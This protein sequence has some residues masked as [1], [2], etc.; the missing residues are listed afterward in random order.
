M[1]VQN[2]SNQS[3]SFF[4]NRNHPIIVCIFACLFRQFYFFSKK[5]TTAWFI[6][7]IQF[8]KYFGMKRFTSLQAIDLYHDGHYLC[9]SRVTAPP[10]QD[11]G[12]N[13]VTTCFEYKQRVFRWSMCGWIILQRQRICWA[14]QNILAW[15][16]ARDIW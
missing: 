3:V 12:L 11:S 14:H 9:P 8:S 15:V 2:L 1:K 13:T 6:L 16:H 7:V 5:N 10:K 4:F